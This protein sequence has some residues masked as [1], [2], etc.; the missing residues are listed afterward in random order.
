MKDEALK[1]EALK[2]IQDVLNGT[3]WS[4]LPLAEYASAL[5]DVLD[6]VRSRLDAANEDLSKD[7]G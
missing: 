5:E 6:D 4:A 7:A 2:E 1:D 3:T